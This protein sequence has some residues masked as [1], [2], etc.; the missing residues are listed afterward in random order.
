MLEGK[1]VVPEE[2][3]HLDKIEIIGDVVEELLENDEKILYLSL[4]AGN[5]VK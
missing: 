3:L 2:L 5:T 4:G 1:F